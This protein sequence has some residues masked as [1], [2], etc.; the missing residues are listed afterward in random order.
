MGRSMTEPE[1]IFPLDARSLG[2]IE[3]DCKDCPFPMSDK[4]AGKFKFPLS[5]KAI[6]QHITDLIDRPCRFIRPGDVVPLDYNPVRVSI[7]VDEKSRII[8]IRF[9]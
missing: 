2:S 8:D 1:E 9:G 5:V 6:P 4:Q 7:Y 3:A